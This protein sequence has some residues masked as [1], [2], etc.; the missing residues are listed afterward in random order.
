MPFKY[1]KGGQWV[2]ATAVRES[3]NSGW[4]L[5]DPVGDPIRWWPMDEG[6]GTTVEDHIGTVG[7][8]INGASWTTDGWLG[9][10]ALSSTGTEEYVNLG[11]SEVSGN[12]AVAWTMTHNFSDDTVDARQDPITGGWNATNSNVAWQVR[13]DPN[14]DT[15]YA[16]SWDGSD[17]APSVSVP[18]S[19]LAGP[20]TKQR[21]VLQYDG[22]DWQIW[23]DGTLVASNSGS[24]G[25]VSASTQRYLLAIDDDGTPAYFF[26]GEIDDVV[27]YNM[28]LTEFQIE[29][30]YQ[31]RQPWVN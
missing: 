30:D 31:D 13:F 20:G 5:P 29:K 14:N 1:R 19:E 7:G 6:A 21:Y 10:Y 28:S 8:T 11:G 23:A 26:N 3:L 17:V 18:L 27:I 2:T 25:A 24:Y 4:G 16:D 15:L 22:T 9:R 12:F